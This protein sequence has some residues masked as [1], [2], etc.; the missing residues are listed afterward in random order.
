MK[1]NKFKESIE[2]TD[3]LLKIDPNH[4]EAKKLQVNARKQ[5]QKQQEA[6]AKK[7]SKMF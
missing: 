1:L 6:E 3:Q 7:Y 5:R 2:L 4:S